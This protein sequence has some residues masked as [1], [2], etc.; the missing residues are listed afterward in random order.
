MIEGQ[1]KNMLAAVLEAQLMDEINVGGEKAYLVVDTRRFSQY[2]I[3]GLEMEHTYGTGSAANPSVPTS[4]MQMKLIDTTGLTFFNSMMDLMRNKLQTTR[5]SAFFLLSIL[6]IGHKDD[7]TTEQ[8]ST[9]HIPLNLLLM[10]FTFTS[11]GSEYEIEFAET[12]GAPQ[13]GA[14]QAQMNYIGNVKSVTTQTSKKNTVGGMIEDLENQLNIQSLAFYQKHKNEADGAGTGKLVQYMIT[15]PPDWHNFILTS[16]TPSMNEEQLHLVEKPTGDDE[17]DSKIQ[18]TTDDVKP[19]ARYSQRTFSD[20]TSIT[21]AIKIILE[22]SNDFMKLASTERR[23]AGDAIANKTVTNITSDDS[24]FLV[25]FDVY[26]YLMPKVDDGGTKI[27]PGT[28]NVVGAESQKIKNLITY[29]YIFTGYNSHIM[30]LKIQYNPESAIALDTNIELGGSR[31]N[32]NAATM[33]SGK[34]EDVKK[35]SVGSAAKSVDFAPQIRP[36]DPIF[37]PMK[38]VAQQNNNSQMKT[39]EL[40]K[41]QSKDALRVKQE[42]TQTYAALH[43]ISSISLDMVV[44][45]NPNIVA[46][47]ADRTERGGMAPHGTP[48]TANALNGLKG[49]DQIEARNDFFESVK[50]G[51]SSSKAAYAEKYYQPRQDAYAR[52]SEDGDALLNNID[53]ATLPVF[54]KINIRAPNVDWTGTY[55]DA[56]NLF[57]DKFFF[58]GPYQVLF[59]KTTFEGG[60]FQH[61]MSL[62]PYDMD[63]SYSASNETAPSTQ[64]KSQ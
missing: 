49:K 55:T 1:G 39:A 51:V 13:V 58:N 41:D 24:T 4:L 62:A 28:N 47:Y 27:Q 18:I 15:I 29:D 38:S 59:I 61:Q 37:I 52:T 9:C 10:G 35:A 44:R 20:G 45:G 42:Y 40:G 25:H 19:L 60:Q 2:S 32:Y 56:N 48:I 16:A 57:T 21:D 34:N 54:V 7:G 36:G 3:T 14:S 26:K 50:P 43:F 6:F 5:A 46:K 53:I 64:K 23:R 22:S 17:E 63:G 33:S 30:D 12:E 31:F 8:V 11:A